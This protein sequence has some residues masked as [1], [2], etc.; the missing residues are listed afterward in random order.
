LE[1]K[2]S[3]GLSYGSISSTGV[4]RIARDGSL[5]GEKGAEVI[6][7]GR[8]VDYWEFYKMSKKIIDEVV[9]AGGYLN[10][11]CSTHMHVLASYYHNIAKPE[12][13]LGGNISE[14]E[15][16][17]PEIIAANLHQLVRRYQNAIT[18]MTMALSDPH[19]LTR[20]E[21][22]RVSVLEISAL[23]L[24]MQ[25]V[26]VEV[27]EHSDNNKY[28]WINYSNSLF[29]TGD[30]TILRF[31]VEFRAADGM[32]SPSAVAALACMYYALVIKAVEISRYGVV[33]VGDR[34]W[35]KK[36]IE[37]KRAILNNRKDYKEGD[38]FGDT[39]GI[40]PY[41]DILI[42]ESMDLVLQ[43]KAILTRVGPAFEVLERLAE[44]PI[45]L[46]RCEGQSWEQIE[47]DLEVKMEKEDHID[48]ALTEMI[49]LNQIK[50]CNSMQ[51][52]IHIVSE[53]LAKDKDIRTVGINIRQQIDKFVNNKIDNGQLVWSNKIGSPILL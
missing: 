23:V 39:S 44:K 49:T 1:R 31:H 37:I 33:E 26:S 29:S 20:W 13:E 15:R 47:R 43:L 4:H 27:Y 52:W 6:T 3:P 12:H 14:M 40:K 5:L 2:L 18:W 22:F 19:A 46:R 50:E 38:R 35:L 32:L 36:A 11:R 10:E 53:I 48:V 17:M 24:P 25:Q 41:I 45:A 21:K 30:G 9:S 16:P 8:R 34:A 51:E 7:T 42:G 28:G